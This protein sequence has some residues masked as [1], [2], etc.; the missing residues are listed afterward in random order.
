MSA[1]QKSSPKQHVPLGLMP[2]G[3]SIVVD[4]FAKSLNLVVEYDGRRYHL[5]A[6]DT[7][8]VRTKI[9]LEK[10]YRVI[11]IREC[12]LPRL[13]ITHRDYTEISATY[14]ASKYGM[15]DLLAPY[16]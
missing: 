3:R 5:D 6:V 16:I 13:D 9:L 15:N 2:S 8:S 12:G 10:G 4:V 14:N 1:L 7:D 11:R